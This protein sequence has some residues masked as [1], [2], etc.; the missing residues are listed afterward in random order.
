MKESIFILLFIHLIE[1]VEYS[2]LLAYVDLLYFHS[3]QLFSNSVW[4]LGFSSRNQTGEFSVLRDIRFRI[5]CLRLRDDP[6]R[7]F[8]TFCLRSFFRLQ[9]NRSFRQRVSSPTISSLILKSIRQRLIE[10]T[11]NRSL[12]NYTRNQSNTFTAWLEI[13]DR[14]NGLC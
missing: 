2:Q 10:G 6:Y 8:G 13:C 4:V 14:F 1:Q 12:C 7:N 5:F 11:V 9:S 3:G